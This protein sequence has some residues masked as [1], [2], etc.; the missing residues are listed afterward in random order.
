VQN[1]AAH[2]VL[3]YLYEDIP[4]VSHRESSVDWRMMLL[5]ASIFLPNLFTTL[6]DEDFDD[7]FHICDTRAEVAFVCLHLSPRHLQSYVRTA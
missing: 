7:V 1:Y 3:D 4:G 2:D 5:R 6:V